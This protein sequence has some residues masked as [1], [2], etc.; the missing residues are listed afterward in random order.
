MIIAL[1]I[2]LSSDTQ[3]F[4][5]HHPNYTCMINVVRHADLEAMRPRLSSSR[6]DA[7][8]LAATCASTSARTAS[9]RSASAVRATTQEIQRC[10]VPD[11]PGMHCAMH[12]FQPN[13]KQCFGAA[14]LKKYDHCRQH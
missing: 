12:C 7:G 8:S 5:N 9:S 4:Y 6:S 1:T 10:V 13:S 11:S 2:L 3:V 14:V